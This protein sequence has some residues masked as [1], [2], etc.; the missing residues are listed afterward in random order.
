MLPDGFEDFLDSY[1]N[2]WRNFS[3]TK[4]REM[5]S[6]DY[7]AREI[8]VESEV[9]DFGYEESIH[10]WEQAFSQLQG[11]AE[12]VLTEH[13]TI[14]LKDHEVMAII[15]AM[16][17]MDG[18]QMDTANLFFQTFKQDHDQNWKLIRSYIEAGIP[19][20]HIESIT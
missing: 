6:Q 5:I 10:G 13:R 12:W 11:H 1:K 8:T 3:I 2:V 4:L 9:L 15:S 14:R 17:K 20:D 19:R 18:K 7:K 16:L